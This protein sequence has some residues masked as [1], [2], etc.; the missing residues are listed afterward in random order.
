M[1]VAL[2]ILA[3]GKGTRMQSDLPKVLHKVAGAPL[4]VHAMKAGASLEPEKTVIVAGHGSELV[5]AA[6][7][8][9]SDDVDVVLQT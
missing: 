9:W 7:Q 1:T 3:A 2:I 6:A 5:A 4:L 8:D